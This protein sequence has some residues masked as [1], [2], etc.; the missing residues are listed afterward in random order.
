MITQDY[1]NTRKCLYTRIRTLRK[2]EHITQEKMAQRLGISRRTYANYERGIH[3]M[4]VEILA[5]IADMFS[6]SL[7]Y[8]VGRDLPPVQELPE[9]REAYDRT[10][11]N[12]NYHG[13][14]LQNCQP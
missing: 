5:R 13:E 12:R 10:G 7:D 14:N 4:P 8:L 11:T 2:K 3:A 9:S 6:T 1:Q